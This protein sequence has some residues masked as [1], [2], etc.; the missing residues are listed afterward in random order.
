MQIFQKTDERT[1]PSQPGD[2]TAAGA[3][4]PESVMALNPTTIT[5]TISDAEYF[6][7]PA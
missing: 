5:G 1:A 2:A 7:I 3:A 6:R 4:A